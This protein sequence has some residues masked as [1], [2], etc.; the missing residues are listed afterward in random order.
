MIHRILMALMATLSLGAPLAFA[1]TTGRAEIHVNVT[2]NFGARQFCAGEMTYALP[3]NAKSTS[4]IEQ[5]Y[6]GTDNGFASIYATPELIVRREGTTFVGGTA[7]DATRL[8]RRKF[9]GQKRGEC[10]LDDVAVFDDL[11]PGSYYLVVPVFWKRTDIP[12]QV[13]EIS[14]R[15]GGT[16]E[17]YIKIPTNYRGGTYFVRTEITAGETTEFNLENQMADTAPN[18]RWLILATLLRTKNNPAGLNRRGLCF[19]L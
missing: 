8:F 9:K 19:S 12:T 11:K 2:D 1:E 13:R 6:P 17:I 4:V 16:N 14:L 15:G 5:F 18:W 7:P 3:V 10:T